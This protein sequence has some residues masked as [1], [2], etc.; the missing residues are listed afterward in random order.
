VVLVANPIVW[1]TF[2]DTATAVFNDSVDAV[3]RIDGTNALT[4]DWAA[5]DYDI[6]GLERVEADT[7][8]GSGVV[9]TLKITTGAIPGTLDLTEASFLNAAPV[10]TDSL[11]AQHVVA[12]VHV[13]TDSIQTNHLVLVG[14]ALLWTS[15]RDTA[16]DVWSD[17]IKIM[18]VPRTLVWYYDGDIATGTQFGATY[19]PE[20]ALTVNDIKLHI[21]TAPVGASLIVDIN[22]AGTTLFSTRPEIDATETREDDNH[23]FDDT[24]IAAGAEIT[25]DI[26]QVGSDTPGASLTV[27]LECEQAL[28]R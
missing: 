20:Q 16:N 12:D 26:D 1:T 19:I 5:G 4:G 11:D 21:E 24:A 15:L 22:E 27:I 23:A 3:V 25:L 13:Q 28:T 6:T 17:S 7:V 18:T 14:N 10:T 2:R 9:Y 8:F